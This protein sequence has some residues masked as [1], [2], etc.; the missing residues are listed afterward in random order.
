[1]QCI[2]SSSELKLTKI[3]KTSYW[4][5]IVG[6]PPEFWASDCR[7]VCQCYPHG[8][9]HSVTGECTCNTNRWGPLCQY[10]CKCARHGLCDPIYGNCTCD[11]GWSTQTCAKPCQCVSGGSV[12]PSCDR[13]LHLVNLTNVQIKGGMRDEG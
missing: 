3:H 5:V 4:L 13:S 6:C 1:M 8:R 2:L 12:R 10:S 11:E 7:Q 9:C